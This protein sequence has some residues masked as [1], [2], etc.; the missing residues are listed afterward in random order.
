M[1]YILDKFNQKSKLY[2]LA[3][4]LAILF[5][6]F[7]VGSSINIATQKINEIFSY[8]IKVKNSVDSIDSIFEKAEASL[9]TLSDTIAFTYEINK[10]N[11]ENYN[12]KYIKKIDDLVKSVLGN[13]TGM[14]GAWFQINADLPFS[15]Y[16]YNWYEFSDNQFI[17]LRDEIDQTTAFDRKITPEN[18]P[19]YFDALNSKNITW[20]NIYIDPDTKT[21]MITASLP[22]YKDGK[23]IGV[24]GLDMFVT[25]LQ[26]SL[27]NMQLILYNSN[28]FLLDKNNKI[29]LNQYLNNDSKKYNSDF[30]KNF[31]GYTDELIEYYDNWIRKAAILLNLT[32][33][34]K[35]VITFEDKSL[36]LGLKNIT[37][38]ICTLI[39]LLF[40]ITAKLISN[41][42]KINDLTIEQ[43]EEK[44][45][46]EA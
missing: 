6:I 37:A 24:V 36:F 40:L 34:Y 7:F 16:A 2:R 38:I 39:I 15:V 33:K 19:Y 26:E 41:Q 46:N 13:S 32:N 31:K 1:Q 5:F 25:N 45:K 28:I 30:I 4:T 12:L 43:I 14:N 20:S 22:V 17:N 11:D 42:N 8:T 18:D 44:I 3:I 9:E 29:I 10:Q 21:P 23:L 27:K 35:V